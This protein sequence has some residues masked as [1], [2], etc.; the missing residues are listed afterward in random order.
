MASKLL[1]TSKRNRLISLSL[2][3]A[4]A[5]NLVHPA[6]ETLWSKLVDEGESVSFPKKLYLVGNA[7]EDVIEDEAGSSRPCSIPR[8]RRNLS[9]TRWTFRHACRLLGYVLI[10][11]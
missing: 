8:P 5:V 6:S 9:L 2:G 10:T 3:R 7:A 11:F 4:G 1:D